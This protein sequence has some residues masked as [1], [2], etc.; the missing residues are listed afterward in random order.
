MDFGTWRQNNM[1][2][3]LLNDSGVILNYWKWIWNHFSIKK[4]IF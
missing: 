3:L 4:S 2:K 1:W